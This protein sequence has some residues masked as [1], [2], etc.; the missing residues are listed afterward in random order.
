MLAP[1]ESPMVRTLLRPLVAGLQLF[2]LYVVIHGHYSPGG[3]FQGGVLLAASFIVPRLVHG[4]SS[5][6]VILSERGAFRLG[7]IG[8]LIF[9]GTGALPLAFGGALLDYG[10]VPT[11]LPAAEL[12]SLAILVV[13]LGVTGA[14]AGALVGMFYRLYDE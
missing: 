8:L 2:A 3:G 11:G 5:G 13:E 1:F 7:V 9:I 6:L 4:P 10:A 12:R 14:V